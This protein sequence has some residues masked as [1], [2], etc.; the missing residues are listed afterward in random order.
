MSWH[1]LVPDLEAF[2]RGDAA[3]ATRI[4]ERFEQPLAVLVL[5][6]SGFSRIARQRGIVAFLAL[7]E[8]MR[9]LCSPCIAAA[10]GRR[11]KAEADNLLAVFPST[12][13]ALSAALAMLEACATDSR[14]RPPL[15]QVKICLGIG[16]GPLIDLGEDVFGDELNLASKLGED[17]ADPG[18]ILLTEAAAGAVLQRLAAHDPTDHLL[19]LSGLRLPYVRIAP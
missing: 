6:M 15:E 13:A 12:D 5:D 11:V 7:I 17:L 4:Q 16:Y 3:A 1:D 9:A 19:A 10:G 8:R 18:E 2:D 14:Q